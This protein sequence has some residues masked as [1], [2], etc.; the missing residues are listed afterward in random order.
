MRRNLT[1]SILSFFL[2]LLANLLLADTAGES[3]RLIHSDRLNLNTVQNEQILQLN[4]NVHFFYGKVEFRSQRAIIW[5]KQKIARLYDNVRIS[6]DTLTLVADSVAYYR[7]TE[8]LRLGGSVLITESKPDGTYR[9]FSCD[10]ALYDKKQ[11]RLTTWQKVKAYDKLENA[12]ASCGY[13]FWDRKAGYAYMVEDPVVYGGTPDTLY[14]RAGRMEYF[15][16]DRKLIATF[17]VQTNSN[18]YRAQSDFLIYFLKAE[19]AVF[20]GNP[21]FFSDYSTAEATEFYLYLSERKLQRAELVDSCSVWFAEEQHGAQDNWV[22]AS[23]VRITFNG[24][25]IRH[26]VAEEMVTYF[27]LQSPK[28]RQD[29]FIN[30][31]SGEYLEA[32]F[33]EDNK[34]DR[35]EMKRNIRG[36]Y[37]FKNKS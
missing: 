27:Y 9:W 22:K 4:G 21:K 24:D 10:N 7:V 3:F 12:Y 23:Y 15:E 35:M 19:K 6:T 20:T 36:K 8:Q 13:A 37:V 34:L 33:N 30:T 29:F 11:D 1:G 17:D 2:L 5:E 16:S 25:N 18:D 32:N 28:P 14:I 26:F 31:A